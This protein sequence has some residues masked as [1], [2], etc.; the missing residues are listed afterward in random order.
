MAL[1]ITEVDSYI[2]RMLVPRMTDVIYLKSPVAT[3]LKQKGQMKF[4]GG[5]QIQRPIM[6]GK[7]NAGFSGP[8]E[9]FD[10]SLAV[11]DTAMVDDMKLAW[12]SISLRG[13]D[14]IKNTGPDSAFSQLESKTANASGALAEVTAQA[15]Y[16]DSTGARSK[17]LTGLRQWLDDGNDFTTIGG[18]TRSDVFT[19]GSVGG[20]NAYTAT[21]STT[22]QLRDLNTAC[23]K[24]MTGA[25]TIDLIVVGYNGYQTLWEAWQPFQRYPDGNDLAKVGFSSFR[26]NTADVVMDPYLPTGSAEG[27]CLGLCTNYLEWYF[28]SQ[29][30]FFY[31]FT[32]MK[33]DQASIDY[34]GQYL[35]A[36]QI[37]Y[38]N[39]RTGFKLKS[40]LF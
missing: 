37:M 39:P 25:D 38:T 26:F 22:M 10:I 34:A 17:Y 15:M 29:K 20:L 8:G 13:F 5:S 40:S 11:T 32:G 2:T 4:T 9:G 35:L 18:I 28:S 36:S 23:V 31:G 12:A 14:A 19:T 7:V 1:T 33:G 6:V 24:A 27:I 16:R 21:L 3:R 30:M